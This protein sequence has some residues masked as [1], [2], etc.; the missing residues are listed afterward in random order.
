MILP[1][2]AM[3]KHSH[4]RRFTYR[5]GAT[6]CIQK[7][8]RKEMTSLSWPVNP[9]RHSSSGRVGSRPRAGSAVSHIRASRV[10][11][12]NSTTEPPRMTS[13]RTHDHFFSTEPGTLN[14]QLFE[15]LSLHFL[16]LEPPPLSSFHS[17]SNSFSTEP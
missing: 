4:L 6:P 11:G 7:P 5:T 16:E 8:K 10:A 13:R 12:E 2:K 9:L 15:P 14:L 3:Y 1:N 17:N